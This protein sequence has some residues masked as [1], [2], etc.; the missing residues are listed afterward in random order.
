MLKAIGAIQLA[1]APVF[2]LPT[3]TAQDGEP[4]GVA[5]GRTLQAQLDATLASI[6]YLSGLRSAARAGDASAVRAIIQA[7]EAPRGATPQRNQSLTRLQDELARLRFQL[8]R[9]LS[10]PAEVAVITAMPPSVV[11]TLG[12][13]GEPSSDAGVLSGRSGQDD[14]LALTSP[15]SPTAAGEASPAVTGDPLAEAG[16]AATAPS[17]GLPNPH[18][19]RPDD[20]SG[21]SPSIGVTTG[22]DA[23][24]RAAIKG[25]PGPLDHVADSSRRR[26]GEPVALEEQGYVADPV[27]LGKLLVRAKRPAEAIEVLKGQTSDAGARYWLARALQDLGRETEAISLYRLLADDGTAGIYSRHAS[28][29]LEF[30]EFKAALEA[31]R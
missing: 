10:D 8:D 15:E 27:H 7:T 21:T 29:D 23:S 16:A 30:L 9:L 2:V 17:N 6:E 19:A 24:I 5:T 3:V 11:K 14:A 28:Q 31:K 20:L 1:L 26:G 25:T 13:G 18:A 4:T 22:L 12:L